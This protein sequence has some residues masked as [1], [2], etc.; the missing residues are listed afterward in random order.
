MKRAMWAMWAPVLQ[1][2]RCT[3]LRWGSFRRIT[4][5][6]R[7]FGAGRGTPIDRY[8]IDQFLAA[9]SADIKGRVMEIGENRYTRQFGGE[10]VT[11]SDVLHAV[12]GNWRATLVGD[13]STGEGL[14]ADSFDCLILTQTLLCIYDLRGTVRNIHRILKPG[15]VAL[16]TIPG[17]S[18]ISRYDMDRWGDYWRFTD[19]SARRLFEEA[20][21]AA[22]VTVET[23][24]NVLVATAFLH[25]LAAEELSQSELSS[26][27][28]DYQVSIMV[29]AVK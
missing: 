27:D 16:V 28:P 20:F 10:R 3:T 11:R 1:W 2:C 14:P 24:G 17:I 6:S 8:F 7:L 21:P 4:P 22:N 5:V 23:R 18:Q 13:L 29:R 25:G 19:R 12:P 9:R 15:G 26:C